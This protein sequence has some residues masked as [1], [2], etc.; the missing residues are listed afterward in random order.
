MVSN[1]INYSFSVGFL[2]FILQPCIQRH[3]R[4]LAHVISMHFVFGP[5][6]GTIQVK[7]LSYVK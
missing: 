4:F 5:V 2:V 7:G 6:N 1:N 3:A